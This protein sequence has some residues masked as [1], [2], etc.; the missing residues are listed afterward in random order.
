MTTLEKTIK[1]AHRTIREAIA[2]NAADMWPGHTFDVMDEVETVWGWN[3]N[4]SHTMRGQIAISTKSL[5][6]RVRSAPRP[7]HKANAPT[8]FGGRQLSPRCPG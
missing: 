5:G 1:T 2:A 6:R 7:A 3:M 8:L 4:E